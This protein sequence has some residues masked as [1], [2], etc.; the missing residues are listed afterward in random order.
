MDPAAEPEAKYD[1]QPGAWKAARRIA[2]VSAVSLLASITV[3]IPAAA[4]LGNAHGAAPASIFASISPGISVQPFP[5]IMLSAELWELMI[6]PVEVSKQNSGQT[7]VVW[8]LKTWML[9]V[10]T[11]GM[12]D[13]TV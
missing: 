13:N 11:V 5:S 10:N 9:V 8:P 3:V 6:L 1:G 2:L 12:V 7:S 4:N